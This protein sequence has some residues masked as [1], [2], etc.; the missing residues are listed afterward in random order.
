MYLHLQAWLRYCNENA[1]FD[2]KDLF[3]IDNEG[4]DNTVN[5]NNK[6][7]KVEVTL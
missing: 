4:N 5:P 6:D 7:D 1:S 3:N 2:H